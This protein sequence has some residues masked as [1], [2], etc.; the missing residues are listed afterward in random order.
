MASWKDSPYLHNLGERS[1]GEKIKIQPTKLVRIAVLTF[2]PQA[3]FL[4]GMLAKSHSR[5][6]QKSKFDFGA[7]LRSRDDYTSLAEVNSAASAAGKV[8]K[9]SLEN[10]VKT[11]GQRTHLPM[12]PTAYPLDDVGAAQRR[13]QIQPTTLKDAGTRRSKGVGRGFACRRQKCLKKPIYGLYDGG[14]GNTPQWRATPH[15]GRGLGLPAGGENI[16]KNVVS[17]MVGAAARRLRGSLQVECPCGLRCIATTD[18]GLPAGG[19]KNLKKWVRMPAKRT[20]ARHIP[21]VSRDV[22]TSSP[23]KIRVR[24]EGEAGIEVGWWW[25]TGSLS[26]SRV[27]DSSRLD[28][29]QNMVG[30]THRVAAAAGGKS[31]IHQLADDGRRRAEVV[32]KLIDIQSR[33]SST[34]KFP[35]RKA[36]KSAFD[37]H[38]DL[39][40]FNTVQRGQAASTR[41]SSIINSRLTRALSGLRDTGKL[42]TAFACIS[43]EFGIEPR[44]LVTITPNIPEM[45]AFPV[46]GLWSRETGFDGEVG[47][48]NMIGT[49]CFTWAAIPSPLV[50]PS[51]P[52]STSVQPK[53]HLIFNT[54]NSRGSKSTSCARFRRRQTSTRFNISLIQEPKIVD[55][56][57]ISAPKFLPTRAQMPVIGSFWNRALA[58]GSGGLTPSGLV[59]VYIGLHFLFLDIPSETLSCLLNVLR[60]CIND[61]NLADQ[62]ESFQSSRFQV[63]SYLTCPYFLA[64]LFNLIAFVQVH[65]HSKVNA[66]QGFQ[67]KPLYQPY[68]SSFSTAASANFNAR[69][70]KINQGFEIRELTR[71]PVCVNS[72]SQK[73]CARQVFLDSYVVRRLSRLKVDVPGECVVGAGGQRRAHTWPAPCDRARVARSGGDVRGAADCRVDEARSRATVVRP[74]PCDRAGSCAD[75]TGAVRAREARRRRW[76]VCAVRQV[77]ARIRQGVATRAHGLHGPARTIGATPCQI[78]WCGPSRRARRAG[79]CGARRERARR[80]WRVGETV[81]LAGECANGL[82]GAPTGS[83]LAVPSIMRTASRVTCT[84]SAH[85]AGTVGSRGGCADRTGGGRIAWEVGGATGT[86]WSGECAALRERGSGGFNSRD[87]SAVRRQA[88]GGRWRRGRG[89]ARPAVRRGDRVRRDGDRGVQTRVQRVRGFART[90]AMRARRGARFAGG[91]GA[92]SAQMR[93]EMH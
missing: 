91:G 12:A 80:A 40:G 74:A 36:P 92:S 82:E 76:V 49:F 84:A 1:A 19:Q 37:Q 22:D 93:L 33:E 69:S 44:L 78:A 27:P 26:K 73:T 79:W 7:P 8:A 72:S 14:A 5:D 16:L 59:T 20:S 89:T 15:R 53:L 57:P 83:R 61:S 13:R 81:E 4:A 34:T 55:I 88:R 58:T 32:E 17:T 62:R 2:A 87:E 42:H 30:T 48:P 50:P 52:V 66:S 24:E 64:D 3:D 86:Q 41:N 23:R 39:F 63:R 46:F 21:L 11:S 56:H 35:K 6:A 67:S 54:L 25:V 75:G 45:I 18:G 28:K 38:V 70:F 47:P 68:P 31:L 77:V 10:T 90:C 85:I 29:I 60:E 43:K 9:M 51:F 71:N 65:S